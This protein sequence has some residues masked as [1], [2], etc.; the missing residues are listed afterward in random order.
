MKNIPLLLNHVSE[1]F[2]QWFYK[3]TRFRAADQIK[4]AYFRKRHYLGSKDRRLI[5]FLYYDMIRNLRLYMWQVQGGAGKK[6]DNIPAE[7]LTVHAYKRHY[8]EESR[9]IRFRITDRISHYFTEYS[10]T[11]VYP[12][13][14]AIRWSVP[15]MLWERI[16]DAYSTEQLNACLEKLNSRADVHIRTNTLKI[17]RAGL[18]R[19]MQD[20]PLRKGNVSP[21]ALR[22]QK[23]YEMTRHILFK[24]GMF[25]F[26]DESSQLVA[27]ACDPGKEDL[28]IDLCAGGGGKSLHLAALM[29]NQGSLTATDLYPERLRELSQRAKRAGVMNIH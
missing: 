23:H 27:F 2:S 4:N 12:E 18:L 16:K 13:H 6:N 10:C 24:R 7:L 15:E 9:E 11:G 1:L 22:L 28:V 29:E 14:P 26:Q 20:I 25:E 3:T 17:S 5:E 21:V 8:P 19:R